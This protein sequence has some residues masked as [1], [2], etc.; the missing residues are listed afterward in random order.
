M[1]PLS[2]RASTTDKN[3][4]S[5]GLG[6]GSV[7]P[8]FLK[9]AEQSILGAFLFGELVGVVSYIENY[10]SDVVL[11]EIAGNI[12]I[13]TLVLSKSSRGQGLTKKMY[14]H[15]F[16]ELYPER[17]IYTRT[18]STNAAHIRILSSFGFSEFSRIIS[19][20]GENIDTVYFKKNAGAPVKNKI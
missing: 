7:R 20:R 5:A 15:L 1:P 16:F 6:A 4:K 10:S 19:D 11:P 9:M 3:L 8:Y 13:S 2:A 14:E 12:Y 17:N 18:W